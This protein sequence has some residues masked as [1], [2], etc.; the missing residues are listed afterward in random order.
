MS[1]CIYKHY[2]KKLDRTYRARLDSWGFQQIEGQHY[3]NTV[4]SSPGTSNTTIWMVLTILLSAGYDAWAINGEGTFLKGKF[5]SDKEIF[6]TVPEWFDKFYPI[7]NTWLHIMKT[8]YGL[9]WTGLLL[10]EN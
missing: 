2:E 10:Q 4:I 7:E 3:D 5:E 6:M 9:N 8:I 1:Y